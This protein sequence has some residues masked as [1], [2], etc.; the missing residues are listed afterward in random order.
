[1]SIELRHVGKTISRGGTAPAAGSLDERLF[2]RLRTLRR[3]LAAG[4]NVPPYLVFNDLTLRAFAA[5]KP[6]TAQQLLGIK[7]V[8]ESK[9]ARYG[10]A[11]LAVIAGGD[12][13]QV[14]EASESLR[15]FVDAGIGMEMP[16]CGRYKERA[17]AVFEFWPQSPGLSLN[18]GTNARNGHA[19]TGR[20]PPEPKV[21]G[22]LLDTARA[23]AF[24]QSCR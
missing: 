17:P 9:L 4:Q 12:P 21:Q 7:G 23:E 16:G 8:G 20:S 22:S 14:M 5:D 10:S 19:G 11:F 15:L 18:K 6:S 1:M 24:F 2:E 13:E 3:L